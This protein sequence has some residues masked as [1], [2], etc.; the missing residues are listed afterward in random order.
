MYYYKIKEE[1]IIKYEVKLH[2][3]TL[4][5]LRNEIIDR[6]SYITHKKYTTTQPPNKWDFE[7][8]RNYN[9]QKVGIRQY[10]DFYSPSEDEYLVEYDYYEHPRLVSLINS[11]IKGNISVIDEIKYTDE[12]K[13]DK[14]KILLDEQK[15]LI[16]DLNMLDSEGINNQIRLLTENQEKISNCYKEKELNK[17]QISSNEYIC[18]ILSCIKF[19]E[20][21]S[22]SLEKVLEVQDFFNSIFIKKELNKTL[23]LEKR[24][25]DN[26]EVIK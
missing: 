8:I 12:E 17:N 7:H 25:R 21:S 20:V 9:E 18:K 4:K 15:K 14:E 6:C 19:K 10:N 16:Q 13:I 22:I 11:L 3:E 23:K 24:K 2:I 5:K 1:L 26:S